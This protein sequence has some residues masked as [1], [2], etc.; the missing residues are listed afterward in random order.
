M[1]PCLCPSPNCL[2]LVWFTAPLKNTTQP[3]PNAKILPEQMHFSPARRGPDPFPPSPKP[4]PPLLEMRRIQKLL[5][6]PPT[7]KNWS[8]AVHYLNR[9]PCAPYTADLQTFASSHLTRLQVC[10]TSNCSPPDHTSEFQST[11]L[12][13]YDQ[14][15]QTVMRHGCWDMALGLRCWDMALGLR[16]WD[17]ALGSRS[18]QYVQYTETSL[19]QHFHKRARQCYPT[20]H[21]SVACSRRRIIVWRRQGAFLLDYYDTLMETCNTRKTK[22]WIQS[23][24]ALRHQSMQALTNIAAQLLR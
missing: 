19:L 23:L 6:Q 4:T 20:L 7:S 10:V 24:R 22:L 13:K 14:L 8:K 16:C 9:R 1:P 18:L 3:N 5:T 11:P 15:A 2:C 17:M 12:A 21:T